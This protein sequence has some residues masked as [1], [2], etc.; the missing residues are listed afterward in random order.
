V[1][2]LRSSAPRPHRPRQDH[3]GPR[4]D[5][6]RHRPPQGGEGARI[7][8]ELGFAHST[9]R[10]SAGR[11]VDVPGHEKFVHHMWP[12]SPGSTCAAGHRGH[13]GSCPRPAT[14]DICRLLGVGS[15]LVRPDEGR[16]RGVEWLDLVRQDVASFLA[17]RHE[18]APVI[19]VS[20]TTGRGLPDCA[21][22]SPRSLARCRTVRPAASR[23]CRRPPLHD[24]GVRDVVTGR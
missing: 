10:G 17:G 20:S 12:A 19:A 13:E 5:R 7:T 22:R 18:N 8:I 6:H 15:G 14:P 2:H 9:S 23:A 21:P 11:V 16:P 1:T 3:A 4:A 24:E